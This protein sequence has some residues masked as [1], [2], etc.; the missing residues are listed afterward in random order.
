MTIARHGTAAMR[1]I[2]VYPPPIPVDA[3]QRVTV[4]AGVAHWREG[5]LDLTMDRDAGGWLWTGTPR[6]RRPRVVRWGAAWVLA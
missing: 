1:A 4:R 5:P 6:P 3:D 2:A